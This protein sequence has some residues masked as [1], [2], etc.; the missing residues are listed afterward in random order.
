[1]TSEQRSVLSRALVIGGSGL[2]GHHIVKKL[3]EANKTI[4]IVVLDIATTQNRVDGVTYVIGSITSANDVAEVLKEHAPEVIFHTVSPNP[5]SENKK[6]FDDVN[7]KGTQNLLDCIQTCSAVKALVYTSSSS[8]IHNSYTDLNKVTEDLP[9]FFAPQQKAYYSHTKAVAEDLIIKA[10]RTHGL[11][12]TSIRPASLF[13]EGDRLL[14]GNM[15][16]LGRKNLVIGGG[17]NN[18]DFT[19]VGNN[20]YAQ[21]LA[22][23]ALIRA[24]NSQDS[25]LHDARVDGEAFV[26]TNDEPWPFW[27]FARALALGAG[28]PVDTSKTRHIP[29]GLLFVLVGFWEWLFKMVTF[30]SRQPSVTTRMIVPTTLERTFDI[31]KAKTRLGYR[32]QVTM[33]EGIDRA[34]KWYKAQDTSGLKKAT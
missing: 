17:K 24:S 21:V 11:L 28:Y 7:I 16:G 18:F 23:E 33:Q 29:A 30:G 3:F 6:R 27:E 26:V 20:A 31:T 8:V 12:T 15:I 25:I 22:A 1:M 14:T 34:T 9:L 19:Y 5:L 10:N 2:L 32:P 4:H 13:G